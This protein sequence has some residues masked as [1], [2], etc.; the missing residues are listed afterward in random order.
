MR[1]NIRCLYSNTI[2][3]FLSDDDTSILGTLCDYYHGDMRTTTREAWKEEICI[4]RKMLSMLEKKD[5]QV[6]FEYDIPRLGKRIDVVLLIN[7]IIFC[8]EFKVGESHILEMDVDQVFDYA[9]DLM[10]FH[11]FNTQSWHQC[12]YIHLLFKKESDAT[13]SQILSLVLP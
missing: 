3:G 6:I 8:I 10:N 13:C 2:A 11:K 9:L 5:G 7:G 12:F 4:M 1:N